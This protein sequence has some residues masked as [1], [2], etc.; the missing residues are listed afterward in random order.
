MAFF[1]DTFKKVKDKRELK[2]KLKI[3]K[4][5]ILKKLEDEDLNSALDKTRSALTLI[6][7]YDDSFNLE[8]SLKE[9][10]K[11]NDSITEKIDK[12]RSLYFNR[13]KKY[14]KQSLTEEN[15]ERFMKLLASLKD[16]VDKKAED[17]NLYELQE[18]INRYFECLKKTY[19]IITN[20]R[21]LTY[22]IICENIFEL[23]EELDYAE[24]SNLKNLIE[25]IYLKVIAKRL[26]E[27]AR[28]TK[29]I[30]L[31]ELSNILALKREELIEKLQE[32]MNHPSFEDIIKVFNKT[33]NLIIFSLP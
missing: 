23:L 13:F 2:K 29:K 32:I 30:S 8:G 7:E 4:E 15:L 31:S 20:Y 11:L 21:V 10:K 12:F 28:K 5:F 17:Y 16:T 3:H 9:F 1:K 22:E 33:G 18:A 26:K 19:T 6:K 24:I 25:R 14:T 27:V